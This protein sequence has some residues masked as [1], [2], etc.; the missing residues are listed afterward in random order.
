MFEKELETV[1]CDVLIVG[2]GGAALRAALETRELGAEVVVASKARVGHSNNTYIAGGLIA[3]AGVVGG[4]DNTNFFLRDTVSS[5]R[6]L[7][8]QKL[9][10]LVANAAKKQIPYM[11]ERGVKFAQDG[12]NLK[13]IRM[14]G[15]SQA[16]HVQCDPPHG[17]H[18]VLPLKERAKKNGIRL[19]DRLFITRLFAPEGHIIGASG[20]T[21]DGAFQAISAKCVIL[22]TG[23]YAHVYQRTNNAT[24]ITGDGLALAYDLGVPLADM[25]FVQFYPT[26]MG[27]FGSK[28]LYYEILVLGLG[29]KL[30]NSAGE[31]I[32]VKYHLD[33]TMSMTRDR[34]AQALAAEI[35]N[36]LG[37]DGGIIMDI[38]QVKEEDLHRVDRMIPARWTIG[39]K[40]LI[41]APTAHFCMGGIKI[42]EQAETAMP[43]LFAAGEVCAGV[44]GA[45]RLGGNALAEVFVMGGVAARNA[46]KKSR[47]MDQ[48]LLP[49]G[50]LQEEKER[51]TYRPIK[52]G[53]DIRDLI[54]M[55]KEAMW[56]GAGVIRE[57][58]SL[59]N[60]LNV[61]EE[62]K[63]SILYSPRENFGDLKKILEF[64]NML[65]I[66]EMISRSAL[67]RTESRGSHYR[68]DFPE[69]DNIEW[70]QNII[71]SKEDSKMKIKSSPVLLDQIPDEG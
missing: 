21:E 36:G 11:E 38:S 47:Q 14:P 24:G 62:L 28:M 37:V 52:T 23:G 53:E 49:V 33:D 5:G 16:R 40:R 29:A 32:V 20:V 43:G 68:S 69:E 39:K 10:A 70:L 71:V 18:F 66:A 12:E 55:L 50:L 58:K 63:S 65:L 57:A 46:A 67:L 41:V 26:S 64:Q 59:K 4:E 31:D 17:R 6:F 56:T 22:A 9:V 1:F 44:H 51:L 27:Q 61:I 54:T 7:N 34:L 3:A 19:L 2:G 60:V 25:E 42:N 45:N 35:Y 48:T 15:H 30:I 8:D 13:V